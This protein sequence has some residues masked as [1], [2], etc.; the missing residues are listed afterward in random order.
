[1][2]N[3]ILVTGGAGYIGAITAWELIRAGYSVVVLDNLSKGHRA[4]LPREATFIEGDIGDALLVEEVINVNNVDR[5]IH[6]AAF[7]LVGE[8]VEQP[9]HYFGNNLIKG[10]RLIEVCVLNG[11][12]HFVLSS[13]AA[14]YG[15]PVQVPIP[16]THPLTPKNPYGFSK[17]GLENVLESYRQTHGLNVAFLRYFN[18]AG[19]DAGGDV[20]EDHDPET[21]LIPII[22][23]AA[24]GKREKVYVFGG[25]YDTPDGTA[26]RDYIHVT[27]LARAHIAVL[28]G[29]DQG[30]PHRAY[31]LGIGRGYSVLEVIKA[32]RE[33]CGQE[34]PYE[35]TERRAGDPPIL[36]A[37]NRRFMRDFDWRP[38]YGDL[39]GILQT[40]WRW[41]KT[42]PDGYEA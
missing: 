34:I 8:S 2:S 12:K 33:V 16:E 29:M 28:E 9:W 27:D 21:H 4:A 30:L 38:E 22:F 40:A 6:F 31:N 3:N 14:V 5:V 17:L 20:G 25:D 23:E 26:I 11:V 42:H 7:S 39:S 19:A 37:D 1:M 13:T 35:I 10:I 36:V 32:A 15:D 24:L 41:H 18:A